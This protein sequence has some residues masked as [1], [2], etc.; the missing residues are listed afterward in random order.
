MVSACSHS[1]PQRGEVFKWAFAGIKMSQSSGVMGTGHTHY[2]GR[3]VLAA[4]GL[5]QGG[6]AVLCSEIQMRSS[7]L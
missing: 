5:V 6:D 3:V 7:I 1:L 4:H 2:K